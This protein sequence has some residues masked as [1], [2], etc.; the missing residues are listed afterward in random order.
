MLLKRKFE[1]RTLKSSY[2]VATAVATYIEVQAEEGIEE[3][4][5]SYAG[6]TSDFLGQ[7]VQLLNTKGLLSNQ[8]VLDLLPL[9]EED[10]S[11]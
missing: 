8:E 3:R 11:P 2:C 1:Y 5:L 9:F 7:L 10:T 6:N 4:A